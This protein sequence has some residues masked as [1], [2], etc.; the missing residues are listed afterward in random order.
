MK[1]DAH[2]K[3]LVTERCIEL[4]QHE[5]AGLAD[6][7]AQPRCEVADYREKGRPPMEP[8]LW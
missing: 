3:L 6:N 1:Y 8:P 2:A 7:R 5:A 4:P